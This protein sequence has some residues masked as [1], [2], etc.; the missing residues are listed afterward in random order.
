MS[1][2]AP[3]SSG[4]ATVRIVR[5]PKPATTSKKLVAETDFAGVAS[6]GAR[7]YQQDAYSFCD[8]ADTPDGELLLVLADGMGGH[9]G[10]SE[11]SQT[12]VT[13]FFNQWFD[14][15][16]TVDRERLIESMQVANEH[17]R[18]KAE[19]NP[20]ELD[21]MGCT[22][23]ATVIRG[24]TLRW[25]SVGDSPLFLYR[26]GQLIRLNEEHSMRPVLAL[27]V[28]EGELTAEEAAKQP[29]RNHLLSAL[30]GEQ[31]EL[32]DCPAEGVPLMPGDI[33]LAASDG[34]LTLDHESI[35]KLMEDGS[36][37]SAR[38][39]ADHLLVE[40]LDRR[41]RKQDNVTIAIIRVAGS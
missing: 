21:G 7:N 5:P 35:R 24:M 26:K 19:A 1:N 6:I 16:A 32:V 37:K 30:M 8:P 36:N 33:I 11:A 12:V 4:D 2:P 18:I 10:G 23:I 29:D 41:A 25:I 15:K 34:I 31:P 14:S 9:R 22:L 40:V 17:L 3:Y 13:T 28:L 39:L 20:E 38:E 27:K